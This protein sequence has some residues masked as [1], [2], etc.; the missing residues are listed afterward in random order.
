MPKPLTQ[1]KEPN[2]SSA[3]GQRWGS[4]VIVDMLHH[5]E[6][7]YA[8]LN[9]GASYRGLHDSMVNYGGNRPYMMLCQHEETAVQIAH[10]YAK[11]SGK[12]MVAILHNLVGLLHANLA[13]YYAYVDRVPIF[14]VGA[15]GP[16]DETRRRP[17]IDW[18]HTALVQGS[19]VRDYTKWDYQ[20]TVVDGVPESFARAYGVMMSQPQGPVYMCYDAWLQEQPLDHDVPLPPRDS[21]PVPA[22]FTADPSALARAAD[23]LA[24]AKRPV[25]LAEFVGRDPR[26]FEALVEL[27]ETLGAPVYDVESRLNFP[28]CHPLNVSMVKDVFRDADLILCLDLRDWERATTELVSQTRELTAIEPRDCVWIDIGFGDLELSSWAMDYQRLKHAQLR[29]LA[30]TTLAIPQLTALLRGK[31]SA[32]PGLV[33]SIQ[34]RT[35]RTHERHKETR[36]KW[37]QQAREDWD[38][39]PIPLPRLAHEVWE[40]IRGEDWVLTAGTLEDWALKL[41]DFDRP[42]RHPGKSLGTATQIGISLG[43]ALAH[44]DAGRLVVDLQPDGDLMFDAGALWVAVKHKIPLLVVMYNNRA[45]YND[46]EHQIR[47]A[48]QRGTPVERAHIG[49]DLEEP[50]VDFAGLARSMGWYAEGPIEHG[51]DVA[52]ALKR[53][54]A[55]VKAG[56]PALL[57]TITQRR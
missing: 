6:L 47:M 9:P 40:A 39:T 36:A 29:I 52:P 23:M 20:P 13:I 17:R 27:A 8:A 4:D 12:P 7:P 46:W 19:A 57:D 50:F 1:R 21:M 37:A 22:Q 51:K 42:Y 11:A 18:T 32:S 24:E 49:M 56:Q 33:K 10:G 43:V 2:P 45:Y 35:R 55:R 26:G 16:M 31:I 25:I 28:N 30:D 14:I 34:E 54:I 3:A 5:Y 41:W 38:A 48:R 44:R 15:T 53:A